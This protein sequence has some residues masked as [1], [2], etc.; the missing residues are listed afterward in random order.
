MSFGLKCDSPF[1]KNVFLMWCIFTTSRLIPEIC[2]FDSLNSNKSFW[3]Y[4]ISFKIQIYKKRKIFHIW[5]V[6][7]QERTRSLWRSFVRNA[8]LIIWVVDTNDVERMEESYVELNRLSKILKEGI[9]ILLLA[10]K[11]DLPGI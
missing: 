6:G 11:R 9:P 1:H 7:G 5:D 3:T 2:I 10:N 8:D 4:L